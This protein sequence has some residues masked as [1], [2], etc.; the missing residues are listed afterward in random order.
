MGRSGKELT[1]SLTISTIRR[2]N[3]NNN[4]RTYYTEVVPKYFINILE[5]FEDICYLGYRKRKIKN[6]PTEAYFFLVKQIYQL[7]K[8]KMN[9]LLR[10]KNTNS[11]VI[12]KKHV[13][14]M[15]KSVLT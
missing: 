11:V 12:N 1:N 14:K 2:S 3:K 10:N 9:V 13:N 8:N 6:D 15:I 5:E 7:L 4:T